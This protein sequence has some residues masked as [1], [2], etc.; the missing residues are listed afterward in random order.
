MM[1]L[2]L[3]TTPPAMEERLKEVHVGILVIGV[4]IINDVIVLIDVQYKWY[5]RPL[6]TTSTVDC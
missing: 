3:L 4:P 2:D 5:L 6:G 1:M